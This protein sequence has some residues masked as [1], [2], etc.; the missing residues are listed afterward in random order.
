MPFQFSCHIWRS[1]KHQVEHFEY[2]HL[3]SSDPRTAVA[4]ALAKGFGPTRS[5]LAYSP[6]VE[7]RI[8]ENLAA[9]VPAQGKKLL[10]IAKRLV[11]PL[12]IFQ[13]HV[14]DARFFGSFSIKTV[15]PALAGEKYDYDQLKVS[16]GM[17]ARAIVERIMLSTEPRGTETLKLIE[18]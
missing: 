14:Y 13:N 12:P 1:P 15:A 11:E 2:L 6:G 9:A 5:V 4:H 8:L 7:R 18:A 17:E 3:D 16:D 10:A